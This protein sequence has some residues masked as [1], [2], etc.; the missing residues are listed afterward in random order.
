MPIK[1][2]Q[3]VRGLCCVALAASAL[4][5]TGCIAAAVTGA[6][7]GAGAA[8]YA[9][10]QGA[11][12]RD[13][14]AQMDLTWAVV[15]QSVTELG[16]P[17][18][19]VVRDNDGGVIETTTGNG[20]KVE[21]R[22]EPRSS[23]VPADGQWTNV[24]IRVAVFGDGQFSERLLNQIDTHMPHPPGPAVAVPLDPLARIEPIP[25]TGPPPLGH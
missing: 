13:F 8:G 4:S 10:Y 25:Q 2:M 11:V 1:G 23:Q 19:K 16:L 18:N 24:S 21:V 9:Y 6:V 20:D 22:V 7:V 12:A 3:V 5:A 14:P 17:L 15:Q